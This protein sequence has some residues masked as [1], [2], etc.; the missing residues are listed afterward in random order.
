MTEGTGFSRPG[1]GSGKAYIVVERSPLIAADLAEAIRAAKG[2]CDI[3][4]YPQA[5]V[6]VAEVGNLP[7]L[8]AAFLSMRKDAIIASGLDHAVADRGGVIV[9]VSGSLG[10]EE[11]AARGWLLLREPFTGE[12]VEGVLGRLV[13]TGL[14]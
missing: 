13:S 14:A 6:A 10:A 8:A 2:E 9:V 7:S 3:R 1:G 4:I 5:D 11:A 12:M